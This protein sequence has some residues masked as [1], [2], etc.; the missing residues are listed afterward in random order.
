MCIMS[1]DTLHFLRHSKPLPTARRRVLAALLDFGACANAMLDNKGYCREELR[2]TRR[3]VD[4]AGLS[5]LVEE[6][7][8]RLGELER[9]RPS[10]FISGQCDDVRSYRETVVRLFLGVVA[11]TATGAHCIDEG[12]RATYC[13]DDLNILFRIAMQCQIIDDV[14][15]YSQD[16]SA[17]LPSFLTASESLPEAM[18]LTRQAA[19]AYA[20]DRDLSRS[21]SV[22]PLRLA[23]FFAA[24]CANLMIQAGR[25]RVVCQ[26]ATHGLVR[27]SR[28]AEHSQPEIKS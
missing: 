23:L 18:E 17:G 3:I 11:T 2:L 26:R 12:M 14:L 8:R 20:D 16:R 15:D 22:F 13:D 28:R 6:F 25:W 5:S 24:I 9:G 1:F 27:A 21:N 10:P 7:L 4:E 19:C